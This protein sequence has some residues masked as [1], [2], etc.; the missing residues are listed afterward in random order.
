MPVHVLV[1]LKLY[2]T[3]NGGKVHNSIHPFH[4]SKLKQICSW[5]E[6][7]EEVTFVLC[8]LDF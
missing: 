2:F 3:N 1:K 8:L 5:Y 6:I 4:V 7:C